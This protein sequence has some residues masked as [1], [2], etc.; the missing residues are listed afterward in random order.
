MKSLSL[1]DQ[2]RLGSSTNWRISFFI[3][4]VGGQAFMAQVICEFASAEGAVQVEAEEPRKQGPNA[5]GRV[6][7]IAEKA[8]ESFEAALAGIRPIAED[9]VAQISGLASTP[10]KVEASFWIKLS[11]EMGVLLASTTAEANIEITL[12]LRPGARRL[13]RDEPGLSVAPGPV[14]RI[15]GADGGIVGTGFFVSRDSRSFWK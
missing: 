6:G 15:K 4:L 14:A 7:K 10:R 11:G 13:M 5:A 1:T 3:F 9:I 8:S 12:K 2:V